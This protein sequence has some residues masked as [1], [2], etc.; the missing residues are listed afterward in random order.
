MQNLPARSVITRKH[1]TFNIVFTN[2]KNLLC[3]HQNIPKQTKNTQIEY[4]QF[5]E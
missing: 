3:V 4:T 2:K 1:L 5:L